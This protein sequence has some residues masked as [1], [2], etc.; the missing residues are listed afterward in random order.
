[1]RLGGFFGHGRRTRACVYCCRSLLQAT[2]RGLGTEARW[3]GNIGDVRV[4]FGIETGRGVI[5]GDLVLL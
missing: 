5:R 2:T 3:E 4:A 1:M